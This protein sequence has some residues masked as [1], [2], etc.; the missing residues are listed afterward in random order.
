MSSRKGVLLLGV[1]VVVF[2]RDG[3]HDR[4][5]QEQRHAVSDLVEHIARGIHRNVPLEPRRRAETQEETH[6]LQGNRLL[7]DMMCYRT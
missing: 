4:Q 5:A 2:L 1:S 6:R 7:E 3:I